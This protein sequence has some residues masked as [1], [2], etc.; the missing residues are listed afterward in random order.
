MT[1]AHSSDHYGNQWEPLLFSPPEREAMLAQLEQ[2]VFDSL[3][4]GA[5][6]NG[7][8]SASALS[9]AG[10]RVVLL[11]RGDFAGGVSSSS[12]NLAWG[13]IKY[14]ESG[15]LTLVRKLCLSRNELM[16]AY[17]STVRE[18]R[19]FTSIRRGFRLWSF[20]VWL[21]ALLYWLMG[22]CRMRA[23]RYLRAATIRAEA[24]IV[25]PEHIVGGLEYSD[26]YLYDN[27][28]RFVF[29]FV[30]RAMDIGCVACNYCE[31]EDLA[32]HD[33]ERLWLVTLKDRVTKQTHRLKTRSV[34]NATGPATDA[35]NRSVGIETQHRHVLSKGIHLIVDRLSDHR[36]VLTFFASDGRLFFVIPMGPKTCIGTTD[37]PVDTAQVGVTEGDRDFVLANAN[38]LLQLARPLTAEDVI[39][40]RVGV[41]PLALAGAQNERD[42]VQL[43]RKH[44]IEIDRDRCFLSIF[45]GKLTD[46]IN[47]GEEVVAHVRELGISLNGPQ[48]QWYGEPSLAK[49]AAFMARAAKLQLDALTP[50]TA[51]EPLSLRFWRRY[52]EYAHRIVDLIEAD[53]REAEHLLAEA[54]YTLAELRVTAE[55][56]MIVCFDDFMRRRSK[57]AQ[58]IRARAIAD[59]PGLNTLAGLFFGDQQASE[60]ADNYRKR[61][62]TPLVIRETNEG[63]SRDFAHQ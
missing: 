42:W 19:F 41:R 30:R 36:K 26:C 48:R 2:S 9:G 14:L 35:L 29:N 32:W 56:E 53:S 60:F 34:I 38:E 3:V 7:A 10:G 51:S 39:A 18:I 16:D 49:R 63:L 15:D 17:P 50:E 6:I 47:V 58:V 11:D 40:E 23:P 33:D 4:I 57:V 44:E 62:E 43:S 24:A 25:A 46:C 61:Y 5:G 27:D 59:D 28:S 31:V 12:S 21:G 22:N 1:D 45:G 20:V 52:G 13:G 54:E 55:R 37:T 8:V